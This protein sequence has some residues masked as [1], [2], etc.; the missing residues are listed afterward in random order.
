[1]STRFDIDGKSYIFNFD[2][3]RRYFKSHAKMAETKSAEYENIIAAEAGVSP[4]SIHAYLSKSNGPGDIKIIE[5]IALFWNIDI[6]TLLREDNEIMS[7]RL[8][9]REKEAVRRIYC[10]II[11]FMEKFIR[12]DGAFMC[13]PDGTWLGNEKQG[14][15]ISYSYDRLEYAYDKE[16]I[17]LSRHPIYSELWDFIYNDLFEMFN[18]KCD[19]SIRYEPEE[20][21]GVSAQADYDTAMNKITAIL[22]KYI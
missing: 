5:A 1:M 12:S 9:D 4:A 2:T 11:D 14:D 21:G 13:E 22:D 8:N 20:F 7:I 18:E 17:D 16:Y 3:F 6:K 15:Y 19:G 10:E